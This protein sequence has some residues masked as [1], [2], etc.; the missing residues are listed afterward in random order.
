MATREFKKDE[1]LVEKQH[2]YQVLVVTKDF[3]TIQSC[4]AMAAAWLQ[5]FQDNGWELAAPSIEVPPAY[6]DWDRMYIT[7]FRRIP[8]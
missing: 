7:T 4:Y 6:R 8:F 3:V 2:T 1:W 5:W